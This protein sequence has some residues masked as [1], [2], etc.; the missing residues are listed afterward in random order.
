MIYEILSVLAGFLIGFGA[1]WRFVEVGAKR[2]REKEELV[3]A[4]IAEVA[5]RVEKRIETPEKR[6]QNLD[7]L[8]KYVTTKYML[9][10]VTLLTPDGLPIASNS[11][12]AEED[13]AT[14]PEIIKIANALLNSD[15]ILLAGGESRIM[16]LQINPEILLYAK[17]TRDFSR[18]EMEKLKVEVNQLLEGLL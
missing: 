13:T 2:E 1:T 4:K 8:L 11:S 6:P 7:E 3:K 10:E 9:A 14:A 16:V 17:V 12:T 15:R 5:E 18:A